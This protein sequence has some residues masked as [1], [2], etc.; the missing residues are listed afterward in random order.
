MAGGSVGD[1]SSLAKWTQPSQNFPNA[2]TLLGLRTY[3]QRWPSTNT[4]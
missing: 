4:Q 1:Q 3:L 2:L